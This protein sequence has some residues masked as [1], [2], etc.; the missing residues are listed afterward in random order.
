MPIHGRVLIRLLAE[1][2]CVEIFGRKEPD[3]S[4]RFIGRGTNLDIEPDGNDSVSVSGIPYFHGL[5]EALPMICGPGSS[6]RMST[7]NCVDGSE[8]ATTPPDRWSEEDAT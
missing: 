7:R 8:T 1:G 2:S 6:L 4:W 5:S 3:G